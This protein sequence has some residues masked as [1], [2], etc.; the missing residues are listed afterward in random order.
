[1]NAEHAPEQVVKSERSPGSSHMHFRQ[2]PLPIT[3][4]IGREHEVQEA[5]ILLRNPE[6]HLLTITGPGGIGKTRLALQVASDV[7]WDFTDGYSFVALA[8]LTDPHQV[9]LTIAQAL[10]LPESKRREPFERLRTFLSKK[11]LLLLLDNFEQVL[12]AAPLLPELLSNC[13]QLKILVTSRAVLR[14][15]GEYEFLVPQ[16]PVPDPQLLLTPESIMQYGAVALFVQRAQAI[17]HDFRVTEENAHDIAAICAR[18]GG[19]PLAIELAAAHI[20]LLTPRL[21]LSRLEKPLDVLTRGGPD[22]PARHQTLRDTIAWSYDLLSPEEQQAFRRLSV[23]VGGSTLEAAEAV[24]ASPGG[25]ASPVVDVVASLLDKSLLQQV[26][27]ENEE[28]RLVMSE[29]VHE[30]SLEQLATSGELESARHAHATYYLELAEKAVPASLDMHRR[31]WLEEL[32]RERDNLNAALH[33]LLERKDVEA[34]LRLA[35]A[36]QQFWFLR[37]SL[38]EGSSFLERALAASKEDNISV[39]PHVRA[40]ALYAAGWL[41]YWQFD[42]EQARLLAEESL[43]L[44]RQVG[45]AR[46]AAATLRFLGTIEKGLRS[47]SAA[48]DAFFEESL[49]IY[50]DS[51]DKEGIATVLLTLGT[52]ALFQGEFA[53]A[54]DLCEESLA[55]FRAWGDSW[56]IALALHFLGWTYYCQGAYAA[57][58]RLSE[59]SIAL[60]RMLGNPRF[61]A[62]A[63]TI[64][65]YEVAA[66]GEE[67]MA[68]S[69]LEEALALG[70]KGESR[71]DIARVLCGLG[72]LALRRGDM[73]QAHTMFGESLAMLKDQLI[74]AEVSVRAKWIPASCL[75]GLGGIAF[76]QGQAALAIRLFGAAE[77][78]RVSGAHRNLVGIEQPYYDR[79][80]AAAR[81]RL[82][83]ETFAALWAEGQAMISEEVLTV[84]GRISGSEQAG[85]VAPAS[86]MMQSPF[87]ELT[88]REVDVLRLLATGLTNNQIAERLVISSKTVNIHV[89]SIYKKLEITSRTAA[90]RY[91]IE[92]GFV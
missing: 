5:C 69:L 49:R 47:D 39:S 48:G 71:L 35:G 32:E 81:T 79:T 70:E 43:A 11:H 10:G 45:D 55:L 24:C 59:E 64:L 18:L 86:L 62:E 16:L 58:R 92:H 31:I 52:L 25:E 22:L 37:G 23:F 9:A 56:Y 53:R 78:L 77:A 46:G 26:K 85:A 14:V 74:A 1:M 50:R 41:S 54:R 72:Y 27:H 73:R 4:L 66:L 89:A 83:E 30:Y 36:L 34:A 90:T 91:A 33:W 76:S 61:T 44:S 63:L 2:V 20:K 68:A 3:P 87:G 8:H 42:P 60:F 21:L 88:A 28:L 7:Q 6:V 12:A 57:A 40:K 75:E 17:Q 13:P 19:L 15:Q 80:L 82:G 29:T 38:H 51:G 67:T 65:A 84:I